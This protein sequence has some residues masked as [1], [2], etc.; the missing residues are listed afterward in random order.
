M[1]CKHFFIKIGDATK[2]GGES[3]PSWRA[4]SGAEVGCVDCGQVRK[5]WADGTVE[6]VHQG[7]EPI[8]EDGE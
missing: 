6:V 1:I 2:T 4:T 7:G 5:V 3:V 8:E